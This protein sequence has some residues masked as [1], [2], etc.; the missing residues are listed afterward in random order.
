MLSHV[1]FWNMVNCHYHM[2]PSSLGDS[3]EWILHGFWEAV[4]QKKN[5]S[6]DF[7]N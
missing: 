1:A 2:D 5:F 7:D 4:Y 6:D 3:D